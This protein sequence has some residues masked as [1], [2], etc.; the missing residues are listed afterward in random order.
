MHSIDK[1][2]RSTNSATNYPKSA[3]RS[4]NQLIFTSKGDYDTRNRRLCNVGAPSD[5]LDACNKMYVDNVVQLYYTELMKEDKQLRED[6]SETLKENFNRLSTDLFNESDQIKKSLEKSFNL[7]FDQHEKKIS[8]LLKR[9]DTIS[10]ITTTT[11]S[12]P[13]PSSS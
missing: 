7:K 2:G 5:P 3:G 9:I 10:T 1:F 11:T 12:T 6:V 8:N 4:N 13:S